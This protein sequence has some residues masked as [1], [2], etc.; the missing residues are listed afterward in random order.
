MKNKF[1]EKLILIIL[2]SF[3]TIETGILIGYFI[4]SRI[5]YNKYNTT[6]LNILNR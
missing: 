1:I 6:Y 5:D 3:I 4:L 2:I